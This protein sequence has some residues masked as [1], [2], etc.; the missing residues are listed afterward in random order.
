M[1]SNSEAARV[2]ERP[3][4]APSGCESDESSAVTLLVA[5][6]AV[7][8]ALF[9]V[10]RAYD[11]ASVLQ[12]ATMLIYGLATL[13]AVRLAPSYVPA[14]SPL[15]A[16]PA[17]LLAMLLYPLVANG[18]GALAVLPLGLMAT[19]GAAAAFRTPRWRRN[20][21][22]TPA[23]LAVG[24]AVAV[25][26]FH[27]INGAGYATVFADV[28]TAWGRLHHDNLF[29]S[30]IV[31]MIANQDTVST[32]LHGL[33]PLAYHVGLHHW[34]AGLSTMM[35]ADIGLTFAMSTQLFITPFILYFLI[36][37][38][39]ADHPQS[40][41]P[42]LIVTAAVVAFLFAQAGIFREMFLSESYALSL[43]VMLAAVPLGLRWL[44]P[45][46]TATRALIP[47][48][49]A[50]AVLIVAAGLIKHST[51]YTLAAF[52]IA[53]MFVLAFRHRPVLAVVGMAAV[54][55]TGIAVCT[56]L[57]LFVLS[58]EMM[59][60]ELWHFPTAHWPWWGQSVV[61]LAICVAALAC[62]HT[63]GFPTM[64]PLLVAVFTFAVS[65]IPGMLFKIAGAS[66]IYFIHPA[67]VIALV[68]A[69][70]A[71]ARAYEAHGHDAETPH[72]FAI[73]GALLALL[74]CSR[75]FLPPASWF[76]MRVD[77][78]R[79]A[80][81]AGDGPSPLQQIADGIAKASAPPLGTRALIYIPPDNTAV[82]TLSPKGECWAL[83]YA[84]PILTG[85]PLLAGVR[86]SS[87]GCNLTPYYG[88]DAYGPQALNRAMSRD[89]MCRE[90]QRLGA[91]TVY[92]VGG[93]VDV[94]RVDC[95]R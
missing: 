95:T 89:E 3:R 2:T 63:L 58:P 46:T 84:L 86:D 93:G 16:T 88:M 35:S 14:I 57:Y 66:A 23:V 92:A 94:T 81:A 83:A 19:L 56:A 24:A 41:F 72:H 65:A 9:A 25:V 91:E 5:Y 13:S 30:A 48:A 62:V 43:P 10:A 69:L 42:F 71:G 60:V 77:T 11:G 79:S 82:W 54:G 64:G 34:L 26:Q 27:T 70:T 18:L 15:L 53:C 61:Y 4:V 47:E 80:I 68:M 32:G 50:A 33:T 12:A 22:H 76:D 52:L 40:R 78:F 7:T 59:P 21:W 37:A 74:L 38:I 73:G 6:L 55:I 39:R 1:P 17:A 31:S 85:V 87:V 67:L 75:L 90:A 45:D 36:Y 28:A 20:G 51:G 49:G 29:H 8:F 44:R